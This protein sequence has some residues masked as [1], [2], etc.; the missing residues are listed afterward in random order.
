MGIIKS[1]LGDFYVKEKVR[2]FYILY[3]A[4]TFKH[5]EQVLASCKFQEYLFRRKLFYVI[6]NFC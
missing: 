6:G 1:P 2:V 3:S 5:E 4:V